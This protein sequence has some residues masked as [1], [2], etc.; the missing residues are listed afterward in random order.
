MDVSVDTEPRYSTFGNKQPICI[1]G[2]TCM[3][4][5]NIE[6]N[7]LTVLM[8]DIICLNLWCLDLKYCFTCYYWNVI[9][10]VFSTDS[11][12]F[13]RWYGIGYCGDYTRYYTEFVN[14]CHQQGHVGSKTLHQQNPAVLNWRCWLMQVDLYNGRKTVVVGASLWT[15]GCEC[16][17]SLNAEPGLCSVLQRKCLFFSILQL[18]VNIAKYLLHTYFQQDFI[19]TACRFCCLQCFDTVGCR[20]EGHPACK[21]LV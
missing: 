8:N 9:Q 19:W 20:Q 16:C 18:F 21:K 4:Q 3:T 6:I 14:V 15:F 12:L 17:S 7:R 13:V 11:D 1:C 2:F 10:T 5:A